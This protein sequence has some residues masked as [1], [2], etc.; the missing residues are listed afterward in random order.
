MESKPM[1]SIMDLSQ[2]SRMQLA[3]RVSARLLWRAKIKSFKGQKF[4]HSID[5]QADAKTFVY[6][7]H[8]SINPS[9]I[10]YGGLSNKFHFFNSEFSHLICMITF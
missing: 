7:E 5:E 10:E 4:W 3:V 6:N 8:V 1:E 2:T 9:I